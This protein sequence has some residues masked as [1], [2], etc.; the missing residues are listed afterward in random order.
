V[1]PAGITE[2]CLKTI[3][4]LADVLEVDPA[5]FFRKPIRSGGRKKAD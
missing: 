2:V 1:V 3:A 4:R 5:E